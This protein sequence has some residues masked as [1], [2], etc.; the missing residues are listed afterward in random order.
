MS[1]QKWEVAI[2]LKAT[3]ALQLTIEPWLIARAN[4][5]IEQAIILAAS[6]RQRRG[7]ASSDALFATQQRS[8][9]E[10]GWDE[11]R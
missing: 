8:Q 10:K 11:K 4:E 7:W 6:R 5:V 9:T 1:P 3:K 2:N